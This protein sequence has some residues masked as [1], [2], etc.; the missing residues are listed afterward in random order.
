MPLKYRIDVLAALKSAGY[1][2]YRLQK[3]KLLS[4]STIQALRDGLP[5]SWA[6]IENL[7]SLLKCQPGDIIIYED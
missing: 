2:T 4:Q 7:C 6:N 1:T 3:D 5:I